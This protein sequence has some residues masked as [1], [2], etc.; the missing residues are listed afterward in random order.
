[1]GENFKNLLVKTTKVTQIIFIKKT[2]FLDLLKNYPSDFV[3]FFYL[4]INEKFK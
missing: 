3:N 4:I 2:M 1:M